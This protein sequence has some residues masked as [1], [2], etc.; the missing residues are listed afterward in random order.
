MAEVLAEPTCGRIEWIA[1]YGTI[2]LMGIFS[3]DGM[4][5]VVYWDARMLSW[6]LVENPEPIGLLVEH[7]ADGNVFV[8]E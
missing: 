8:V 4:E 7:D 5:H 6:F 1:D 2:A 3:D